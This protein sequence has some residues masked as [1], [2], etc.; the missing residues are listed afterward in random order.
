MPT[1]HCL[2]Q[3]AVSIWFYLFIYF[4]FSA[5]ALHLSLCPV[6][7]YGLWYRVWLK[8]TKTCMCC[9]SWL[10]YRICH[11]LSTIQYVL[12]PQV[13]RQLQAELLHAAGSGS[14]SRHGPG[15]GPGSPLQLGRGGRH[16]PAEGSPQDQLRDSQRQDSRAPPACQGGKHHELPALPQP[17]LS[18]EL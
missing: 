1:Q 14:R 17:P 16:R 2:A 15:P 5:S 3:Y 11:S 10:Q 13:Q 8:E 6:R 4:T 7:V 9:S 12:V 18:S